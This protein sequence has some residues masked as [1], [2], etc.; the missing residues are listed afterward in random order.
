LLAHPPVHVCVVGDDDQSIYQWRGADVTNIVTFARRYPTVK[1]F[2]LATNRRSRPSI[3]E[4]A[5]QFATSISGRLPKTMGTH[6]PSGGQPEVIC[7]S[8]ETEPEQAKRIVRAVRTAHDAHGY[9]YRDIAILCRGRS[10]IPDILK[11]LDAHGIPVQPTGRTNLFFQDDADLFGRTIAWLS[12]D[13]WF[14]D[15]YNVYDWTQEDVSLKD[16]VAHYENGYKLSAGQLS[17]VQAYLRKWKASVED[18]TRPANLVRDF[19]EL[20]RALAVDEWDLSD[21]D[22]INRLGTLARCSQ[23]LAD[24]ESTRRRARPDHTQPGVMRGG[25]DRGLWYYKMLAIYLKNWAQGA[26]EGFEGEEDVATDAVDVTTIHQAKGLEWPIVF[27]PSLTAQRFPAKGGYGSAWHVP[28]DLFRPER[29]EGTENDERRLFYV[30]MTRARDVLSLST[31]DRTEKRRA[32]PS[33][34]LTEVAGDTIPEMTSFPD[35]P[36]PDMG[37][38]EDQ[39]LEITFSDLAAYLECGL[40]YRYRRLIGFQPPLAP[41]IG[42]GKAVH[43]VLRRIADHVRRYGKTPTPKQLERLFTD[44]FYLP[45][46]NKTAYEEMRKRAKKLVDRYMEE[47][48]SD[49]HR[50]WEVE[51][52]FELHLGEA[53]VAGRA[54]VILDESEGG[55]IRLSIVDY[56]TAAD[57]HGAHDFQLQIYTNAGRREGLVVDN[58]YVHDLKRAARKAVPVA[59][60]DIW[61][62]EEQVRGLIQGLRGKD[63]PAK[64]GPICAR[65][66]VQQICKY[67]AV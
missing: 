60:K 10:S 36:E 32:N 21:T 41:E 38:E 16:L 5:N 51:R 4:T 56:K 9:R 29:Y 67:R 61:T 18:E 17:A 55:P 30:A 26:Y 43:H 52:P 28:T 33:S 59:E 15:R 47:W 19:Y 20:L 31:F 23:V 8:T 3:I 24:Y 50:V 7:W 6:R 54:D 35:P 40:S 11:A 45:A 53:T 48:E 49:L 44:E 65:C 57:G 34:F 63:Y 42:Y 14:V 22:T 12:D 62:A 58:A 1:R 37:P 13:S 27:V 46:A 66:D 39:V 25:Q 2:T 64:P